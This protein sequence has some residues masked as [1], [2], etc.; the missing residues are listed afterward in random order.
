MLTPYLGTEFIMMLKHDLRS[1][2]CRIQQTVK[3][4][5]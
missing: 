3:I 2:Q 4:V 5:L 1:K